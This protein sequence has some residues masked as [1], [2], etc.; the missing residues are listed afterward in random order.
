MICLHGGPGIDGGYMRHSVLARFEVPDLPGHGARAGDEVSMDAWVHATVEALATEPD[1]PVLLGHSFGGFIALETALRHPDAL[2]ALVLVCTGPGPVS[3]KPPT[4]P[5]DRSVGAFYRERWP[6]FFSGDAVWGPLDASQFSARAFN[7]GFQH[8]LPG[9]QVGHRLTEVKCPVLLIAGESDG[10]RGAME[11]MASAVPQSRLV[12]LEGTKHLP[13]LEAPESFLQAL[14]GLPGVAE[15][16]T[17]T[18]R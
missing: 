13:F 15:A 7:Q 6:R 2:S 10:Y 17:R 14:T 8:I 1:P 4:L 5:D 16:S 18:H 11:A 9:W 3:M 12:V